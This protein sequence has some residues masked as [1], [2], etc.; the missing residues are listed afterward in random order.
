MHCFGSTRR[1]LVGLLAAVCAVLLPTVALAAASSLLGT[2]PYTVN[3]PLLTASFGLMIAALGRTPE[4]TR[5]L[6]ILVTLLMV[7]LGGAWVPS[8]LFP[9]WVQAVA[10][11]VPTHWAVDGF[12]AMTWRG[13]PLTAALPAVGSLL[14]F[15]LL[16]SAVALARFRW[17]E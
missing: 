15:S 14:A 8:F 2:A 7:M 9:P 16:F 6:A 13:L 10:A 3:V 1:R 11:W 4:V 5:G 17:E 12:D